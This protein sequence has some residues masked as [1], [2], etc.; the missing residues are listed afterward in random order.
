MSAVTPKADI[1]PGHR[2]TTDTVVRF[3]FW[4]KTD[5]SLLPLLARRSAEAPCDDV[6]DIGPLLDGSHRLIVWGLDAAMNRSTPLTYR[7]TVDT[8]PADSYLSGTRRRAPSPRTGRPRSRCWQSEPGD[9]LAR[10]TAASSPHACRRSGT[11]AWATGRTCSRCT[12]AIAPEP[13]DRGLP[14]VDGRPERR[15]A[16]TSWLAGRRSAP[17]ACR[18]R[19]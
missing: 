12:C 1:D 8:I 3:R 16:L 19:V 7:F 14:L 13:V 6:N 4:S 2:F 11:R 15:V 17:S 9:V 10:S 18:T 5:P